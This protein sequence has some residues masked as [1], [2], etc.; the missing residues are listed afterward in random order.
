MASLTVPGGGGW[1]VILPKTAIGGGVVKL[2]DIDPSGYN[3]M[4]VLMTLHTDEAVAAFEPVWFRL[5]NTVFN[6]L[7]FTNNVKN[8]GVTVTGESAVDL[9]V[10][11]IG[12]MPRNAL[13]ENV[14]SYYIVDV[15]LDIDDIG[16]YPCVFNS[17]AIVGTSAALRQTSSG[18]GQFYGTDDITQLW[19]GSANN[20]TLGSGCWIKVLGQKYG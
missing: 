18:K 8:T 2:Q 4:R 3:I 1:E 11:K 10:I 16:F 19:I 9:N 6:T 13:A 12:S 17:Y 7:V 5:N 15:D 20:R 14:S